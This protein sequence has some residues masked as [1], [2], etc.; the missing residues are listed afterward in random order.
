MAVPDRV[1]APAVDQPRPT[2]LVRSVTSIIPVAAVTIT[3]LP[4][5]TRLAPTW[6]NPR[7]TGE[8]WP[9]ADWKLRFWPSSTVRVLLPL[10]NVRELAVRADT[11]SLGVGLGAGFARPPE[12]AEV[13]E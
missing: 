4:S 12:G 3:W 5:S 11:I 10:S 6:W 13:G 7:F 2:P 8:Y 9:G 1:A